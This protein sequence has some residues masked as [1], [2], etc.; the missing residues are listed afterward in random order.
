MIWKSIMIGADFEGLIDPTDFY[1][2]A[3]EFDIF[4]NNPIFEIKQGRK[5]PEATKFSHLK[6]R[7]DNERL[8]D[9]FCFKNA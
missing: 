1:P 8:V 6:S 2:T 5:N 7:E 9:D 3:L 4:S